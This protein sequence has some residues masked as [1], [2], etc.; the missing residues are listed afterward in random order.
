MSRL[1]FGIM[2]TAA[3]THCRYQAVSVQCDPDAYRR[4]E[5]ALLNLCSHRS[6]SA[7]RGCRVFRTLR[8]A[9]ML[10]VG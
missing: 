3:C 6:H 1:G 8:D 5:V 9:K 7:S 2:V 4:V 10:G